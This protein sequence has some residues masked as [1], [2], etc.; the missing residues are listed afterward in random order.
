M[1]RK[2]CYSLKLARILVPG[3]P[4]SDNPVQNS[5]TEIVVLNET[6]IGKWFDGID[7]FE[8][9]SEFSPGRFETLAKI[10]S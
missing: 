2:K 5:E 6:D 9:W 4:Q 8:N 10:D 3:V 1:D 7:T